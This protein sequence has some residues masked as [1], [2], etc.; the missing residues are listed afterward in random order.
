MSG[1][2][3]PKV[4]VEFSCFDCSLCVGEHYAWQSDSG[5]D[6][7]CTHPSVVSLAKPRHYIGDSNWRTPEWCPLRQAAIDKTIASLQGGN[8]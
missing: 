6:V 8:K 1:M 3:G 7:Y 5:T 2:Q 4:C